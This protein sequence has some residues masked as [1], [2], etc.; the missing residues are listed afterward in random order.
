MKYSPCVDLCTKEGT[1]C[2]GCGRSHEEIA[3]TKKLVKSIVDF[4][5]KQQYD[6]PE[7]FV[8]KISRSTL[9]KLNKPVV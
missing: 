3:E 2:T 5:E 8:E 1:H 9:K 4:I 6:N 7:Q